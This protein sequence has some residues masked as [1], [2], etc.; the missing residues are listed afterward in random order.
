[1][2]NLLS[3]SIKNQPRKR[4]RSNLDAREKV[5][6]DVNKMLL[7]EIQVRGY[8]RSFFS[9]VYMRVSMYL[10]KCVCECDV[11]MHVYLHVHVHVHVHMHARVGVYVLLSFLFVSMSVCA[12]FCGQM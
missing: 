1:M 4:A 12:G 8:L 6:S 5:L 7:T 9:R 11:H 3:S 10:N 2:I